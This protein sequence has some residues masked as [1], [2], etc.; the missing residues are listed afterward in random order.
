V[1]SSSWENN[2]RAT[3]HRLAYGIIC[4]L[5][6]VSVPALIASKPRGTWFAFLGG[7][8]GW[9][10]LDVGYTP[11]W[12]SSLQTVIH[13][14]S[15]HF[16]ISL[17]TKP[18]QCNPVCLSGTTLNWDGGLQSPVGHFDCRWS[19]RPVDANTARPVCRIW[20]CWSPN[21]TASFDDFPRR[22]RC[23]SHLDQFEPRQPHSVRLLFW[24]Q[25]DSTTSVVWSPT[26]VG[27]LADAL[28]SIYS[29]SG[30][31]GGILWTVSTLICWRHPDLQL[32]SIRGHRQ[33]PETCC[34]LCRCRRWLDAFD[35]SS[36]HPRQ[37]YCGALQPVDK[38]SYLP[39]RWLLALISCRL[40]D[41]CTIP[42]FSL[43]L[44][45]QCI[46][47][48]L[49]HV[50]SVLLLFDNYEVY[51]SL[52]QTTWCSR[53]SWRWF[54]PGLTTAPQLLL[55]FRSNSWTGFSLCRTPLHG[56]SL[57]LVV[58]TAFCCYCTDYTG[59]GC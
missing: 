47:K 38:V 40:S 43:T 1:Y 29:R 36:M 33:S 19:R 37:K 57:K 9:V 30:T 20:Y 27:L 46:P 48:S 15:M 28:S 26:G 39:I 22:Q 31:A 13:W 25:V 49:R 50:R 53:S 24:I 3:E 34:W 5:T 21:L 10:D 32:L 59:F 2:Q 54:F 6:K 55:A 4:Q 16:F 35:F 8:E 41:A 52:C 18:L 45:W 58:R 14:S 17:V 23:R 11:R 7:M 12:F 51:A 42:V 44:T 56:W